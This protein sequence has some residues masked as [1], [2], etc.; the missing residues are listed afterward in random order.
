[1]SGPR[2]RRREE[3]Q[4]PPLGPAEVQLN[5][6]NLPRSVVGDAAHEFL[7]GRAIS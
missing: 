7:R 2:K 6:K 1:M 3:A 4:P 5:Y